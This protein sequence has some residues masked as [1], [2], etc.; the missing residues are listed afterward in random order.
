[1]SE[2]IETYFDLIP[3]DLLN[4]IVSHLVNS[5]DLENFGLSYA[6]LISLLNSSAVG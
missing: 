6:S 5:D 4:I 2:S 3:T 1:M